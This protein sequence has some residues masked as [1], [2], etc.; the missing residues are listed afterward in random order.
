MA[1]ILR[2]IVGIGF[3]FFSHLSFSQSIEDKISQIDAEKDLKKK[4]ILCRDLSYF[5][6]KKANYEVAIKYAKLGIQLA[7]QVNDKRA[8]SIH[9]NFLAISYLRLGDY[10][11][12]LEYQFKGLSIAKERGDKRDIAVSY[13]HIGGIYT[14]QGKFEQALSMHLEALKLGLEINDSVSIAGSHANAG[15]VYLYMKDYE[16]AL[17]HYA[18]SQALYKVLNNEIGIMVTEINMGSIY[19][20]EKKYEKALEYYLRALEMQDRVQNDNLLADN[21]INIASAYN[22]LKRYDEALDFALQA[23]ELKKKFGSE[24][25]LPDAYNTLGEVYAGLNQNQMALDFLKESMNIATKYENANAVKESLYN[26]YQIYERINQYDSAYHYLKRH[27]EVKDSLYG[28][29]VQE[30]ISNLKLKYETDKKNDEILI[31]NKDKALK[32]FELRNYSIESR[33]REQEFELIRLEKT[34]GDANLKLKNE[35][36]IS[37]DLDLQNKEGALEIAMLENELQQVSLSKEKANKRLWIT[38]LFLFMVLGSVTGIS[39]YHRRKSR[40]DIEITQ[41]EL[42]TLRSQMKPHFIFNVLN[43][44]NHFLRS[45]NTEVASDFLIRFSKLIRKILNNAVVEMVALDEELET[46]KALIELEQ[47][48]VG[49]ELNYTL[50]I[51]EE[52]DAE[53]VLIPS[54]ILQPIVENAIWHGLVP[55]N[56]KGLIQ[57]KISSSTNALICEIEDNG[58]GID[59]SN[60]KTSR[61]NNQSYGLKIS[62]QRLEALSKKYKQAASILLVDTGSGTKA[63]LSLP[64]IY[65]I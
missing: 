65:K 6:H 40:Y 58:I 4:E 32:E 28:I 64:L 27:T 3:V 35:E 33:R 36:L 53:N 44:I 47:L 13:D 24:N 38:S 49:V 11:Q 20:T 5:A 37:K 56:K 50:E 10:T 15:N 52:I 9:Y 54:L 14:V 57:I 41:L 46:I 55:K 31:L 19:Y 18:E 59:S 12:C 62:R 39:L 21:L 30:K 43:S 2:I 60:T 22:S 63:I 45:K 29:E 8:E 51:S 1:R 26:T 48:N 23:V 42:Q 61:H 17:F 34:L 16:Q 25:L 7:I